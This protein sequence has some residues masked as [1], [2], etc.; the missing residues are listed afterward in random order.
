M[1][2]ADREAAKSKLTVKIFCTR[3]ELSFVLLVSTFT[4]LISYEIGNLAV[5]RNLDNHPTHRLSMMNAD[6]TPTM[7]SC[8]FTRK[9]RTKFFTSIPHDERVA[10]RTQML[11]R[12]V[13]LAASLRFDCP[14]EQ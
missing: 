10:L 7:Q 13:A 12:N 1:N 11:M 8:S 3:G 14:I 2:R 9:V 5:E 6:A 4:R